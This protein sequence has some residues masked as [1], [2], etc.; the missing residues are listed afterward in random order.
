MTPPPPTSTLFP[1]TTLFRSLPEDLAVGLARD[2]CRR[3][4]GR[5]GRRQRRRGG[6]VALAAGPVAGH[7]VLLGE[8][9][10]VGEQL[11]IALLGCRGILHVLRVGR[12]LPVAALRVDAR[13]DPDRK[14]GRDRKSVV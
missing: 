13:R 14:R 3:P 11:G 1:Y 8:L 10:R 4:V 2:A 6:S 5:L 9:L 7:A 12:R